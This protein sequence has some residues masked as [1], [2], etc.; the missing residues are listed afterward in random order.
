[1][2][3][4]VTLPSSRSPPHHTIESRPTPTTSL[5]A[6]HLLEGT[7]V[8]LE[9]LKLRRAIQGEK[10][11]FPLPIPGTITCDLCRPPVS[12]RRKKSN[13]RDALRHMQEQHDAR[14]VAAF[15]CTRCGYATT[16]LHAGNRHLSRSC[17]G[18]RALEEAPQ[19][20]GPTELR[21]DG[22]LVLLWPARPSSCPAQDCI[23]VTSA[24]G[25]TVATSLDHHL[26]RRHGIQMGRRLWRCTYCDTTMAG[27]ETRE[28]RCGGPRRTKATGPKR[29]RVCPPVPAP[30]QRKESSLTSRKRQD[31]HERTTNDGDEVIP[32]A[33]SP[34]R[35]LRPETPR[36]TTAARED[37][38]GGDRNQSTDEGE[39][40]DEDSL[41]PPG[42]TPPRD[43][44][45]SAGEREDDANLPS[46]PDTERP[47]P[48][49]QHLSAGRG[50]DHDSLPPDEN[51]EV[52]ATPRPGTTTRSGPASPPP[53]P[54][55]NDN[56]NPIE[57]LSPTLVAAI[58]NIDTSGGSTA[59]I[60]LNERVQ[61]GFNGVG[62]DD[63]VDLFTTPTR[64]EPRT[65]MGSPTT[66]HTTPTEENNNSPPSPVG[67]IHTPDISPTGSEGPP[68]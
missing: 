62:P 48:R 54:I 58:R 22:T 42:W 46:L 19:E 57:E 52:R 43:D 29:P 53:P 8:G 10:I 66:P 12:W 63:S 35:P 27:L 11:T 6:G 15:R 51:E 64:G 34:R 30:A 65:E 37:L 23:F 39:D 41:P 60:Y 47:G 44:T 33:D 7:G 40:H 17:T 2:P 67:S 49:G 13:H 20:V 9:E 16:T 50:E 4:P 25:V 38:P 24:S 32:A 59:G 56:T 45:G 36:L 55:S 26:A 21:D 31:E 28:H 5:E 1:M 14:T 68:H 18:V 61:H 3:T